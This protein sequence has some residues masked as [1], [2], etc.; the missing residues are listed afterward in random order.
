VEAPPG[1]EKVSNI[2]PGLKKGGRH[3]ICQSRLFRRSIARSSPKG[4]RAPCLSSRTCKYA[5]LPGVLW[6]SYAHQPSYP[7]PVW[8]CGGRHQAKPGV[9]SLVWQE[10]DDDSHCQVIL[11]APELLENTLQVLVGPIREDI[12]KLDREARVSRLWK[13]V[14]LLGA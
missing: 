11:S 4:R 3:L 9:A 1:R 6:C 5:T 2:S 13:S 8:P 10:G 12:A 7:V 14:A